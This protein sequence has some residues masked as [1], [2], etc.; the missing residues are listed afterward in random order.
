MEQ[1]GPEA[2]YNDWVT[3]RLTTVQLGVIA[4]Q[5]C[6][7]LLMIGSRGEL[8][9]A[10]PMSDDERR[11]LETH[12][13]REFGRSLAVQ[14]KCTTYRLRKGRAYQIY[15]RFTVAKERLVSH[16][17]FWYFF[18]YLDLKTMAFADP[19][20][21]VPSSELHEHATRRLKDGVW[22]FNFEASLD[23]RSRDRWHSRQVAARDVGKL[24]LKILRDVPLKQAVSAEAASALTAVPEV[25]WVTRRRR[26]QR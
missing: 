25:V 20:F 5:E 1:S 12:I 24:V 23:R 16:P 11:D 6:A 9:V 7:K 3:G 14:V 26:G 15:I 8:E 10:S 17:L 21:L 2:K 22:H 18:A 19:V 4:Q 13:R